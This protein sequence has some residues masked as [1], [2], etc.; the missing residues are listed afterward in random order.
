MAQDEGIALSRAKDLLPFL[1]QPDN[2][3]FVQS[4]TLQLAGRRTELALPA[5]HDDKIGQG[6][7]CPTLLRETAHRLDHTL[8]AVPCIRI[9]RRTFLQDARVATPDDFRHA[10]K[11]ILSLHCPDAIAAVVLVVGHAIYESHH[12]GH[13]VVAAHI[14]DVET[15]HGGGRRGKL[16][17]IGQLGEIVERLHGG[18]HAP[19]TG[20]LPGWIKGAFEILH[21][22]PQAAR[23]FKV[24]ARRCLLHFLMQRLETSAPPLPSQ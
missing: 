1:G 2:G 3:Q 8:L 22:V 4:E 20:E 23:P 14:R 15:L 19:A 9:D 18:G 17:K 11:V 16:Q 13:V 6:D 21:D 24:H 5:I 7:G 12:G 10:G